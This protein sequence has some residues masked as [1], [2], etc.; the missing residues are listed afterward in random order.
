[1]SFRKVRAWQRQFLQR[2]TSSVVKGVLELD[3]PV[4]IYDLLTPP[5]SSALS[6][7]LCQV[8]CA[9]KSCTDKT[10]SLFKGID[11]KWARDIVA[12]YDISLMH[13]AQ[14]FLAH[15]SVYLETRFG[16]AIWD[17]FTPDY[18]NNEMG[19]F[20][21][22]SVTKR[23]IDSQSVRVRGDE[24]DSDEEIDDY[25]APLAGEI[26][27]HYVDEGEYDSETLTGV[28]D[29]PPEF[30]WRYNWILALFQTTSD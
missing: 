8:L 10:K 24:S 19:E 23:V 7:T 2:T 21:W 12:V 5:A 6:L 25:C 29:T 16:E 15:F 1:M 9:M 28:S 13:E 30:H 18:K 27:E 26:D 14:L 17:W 22:C 3:Y 20:I 4:D 11:V